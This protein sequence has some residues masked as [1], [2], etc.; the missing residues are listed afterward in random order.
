V[1]ESPAIS[2]T[3]FQGAINLPSISEKIYAGTSKVISSTT[4][5]DSIGA[6]SYQYIGDPTAKSF[7]T[8]SNMKLTLS[9][10]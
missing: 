4:F 5:Q 10:S 9:P 6:S 1:A 8:F 7:A 2:G 3:F